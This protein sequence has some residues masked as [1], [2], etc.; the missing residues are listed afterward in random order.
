MRQG[1]CKFQ[2]WKSKKNQNWYWRLRSTL[3]NSTIAVAGE[4]FVTAQGADE[5][6]TR[7]LE[8]LDSPLTIN[9][10]TISDPNN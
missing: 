6:M 10:E 9:I 2:R 8:Y 5:S 1:Q 7:L 3:N 4:G